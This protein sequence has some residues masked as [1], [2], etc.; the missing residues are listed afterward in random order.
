MDP[1]AETASPV[2]AT[3]DG[4]RGGGSAAAYHRRPV[5]FTARLLL[6]DDNQPDLLLLG[7]AL[8]RQGVEVVPHAH[9][10]AGL[11]W[12]AA[13]ADDLLPDAIILDFAMPVLD[14]PSWLRR[15]R[16]DAR[17]RA[18]PVI[19]W[20][21]SDYERHHDALKAAG[22]TLVATK[23]WRFEGIEEF[24]ALVSGIAR[25]AARRRM[26]APVAG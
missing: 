6:I 2:C 11:R 5:T 12:L 14:G 15:A 21:G 18:V 20:T 9:P 4:G 26:P 7:E 3:S 25:R 10:E 17:L 19:G 22:A 1:C 13:A 8:A 24:A 16:D 23:S